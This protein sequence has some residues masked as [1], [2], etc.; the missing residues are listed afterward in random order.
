MQQAQVARTVVLVHGLR[1]DVTCDQVRASRRRRSRVTC[2]QLFNLLCLFGNVARI[3][4][5]P[6]KPELA[7]VQFADGCVCACARA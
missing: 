4:H 1:R 6:H 5:L 3:K 7:L 2:S